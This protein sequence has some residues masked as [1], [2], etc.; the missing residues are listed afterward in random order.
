[1]SEFSDVMAR[2]RAAREE[3][4]RNP[5]FPLF[6]EELEKSGF[7]EMY[8]TAEEAIH[9]LMSRLWT[10]KWSSDYDQ[11]RIEKLLENQ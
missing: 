9:Q 5:S 10:A 7:F 8:P 6:K 11:V 4:L 2:A 1:M 3:R